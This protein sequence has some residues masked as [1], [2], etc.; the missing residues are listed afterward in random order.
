[1]GISKDYTLIYCLCR[2]ISYKG[3]FFNFVHFYGQSV[4]YSFYWNYKIISF[5][6]YEGQLKTFWKS[7]TFT[8]FQMHFMYKW[9]F[10]FYPFNLKIWIKFQFSTN[11]SSHTSFPPNQTNFKLSIMTITV[12]TGVITAEYFKIY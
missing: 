7:F 3:G 9:D 11:Y 8:I 5:F 10:Y 12:K 4:F 2:H 1:M 6:L